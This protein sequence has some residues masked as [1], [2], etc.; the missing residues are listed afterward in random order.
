MAWLGEA[1]QGEARRGWAWRGMAWAP[2]MSSHC[3]SCGAE[4]EWAVTPKG[5]R[6]P[7]DPGTR[8][9][10]NI[11]VDAWGTAWVVGAWQG[12]RVSHFATCPHHDKHRRRA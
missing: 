2:P 9:D 11:Q 10:G 5:R 12:D 8:D 4:I 6:I 7:L 3:R 1:R